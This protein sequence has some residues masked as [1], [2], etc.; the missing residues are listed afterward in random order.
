MRVPA[1]QTFIMEDRIE[2]LQLNSVETAQEL[3][4][5]CLKKC[6]LELLSGPLITR[7]F[8]SQTSN[9]GDASSENCISVMQWNVLSQGL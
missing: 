9:P 1:C 2:A 6:Q 8:I 4:L 3:M 7:P 5:F